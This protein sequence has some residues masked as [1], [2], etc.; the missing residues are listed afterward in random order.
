MGTKHKGEWQAEEVELRSK[1]NVFLNKK[2]R[3]YKEESSP[4]K[5]STLPSE[6]GI[7]R[8]EA[9]D[10]L[11]LEFGFGVRGCEGCEELT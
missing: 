11:A 4:N 6:A 10:S 8:N 3:S 5:K 9:R 7:Q 1:I 2:C